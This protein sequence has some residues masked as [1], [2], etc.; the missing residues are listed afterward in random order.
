M[1]LSLRLTI[2]TLRQ[3]P[4]QFLTMGFANLVFR[5]KSTLMVEKSLSTNYRLSYSS[6]SNVQHSKTSPYHLQC[7]AQVKVFNKTVKKYLASYVDE[8]TLNW[9]NFLPAFMLAYNMSYHSTIAMTP[10]EL[11]FGVKPHLPSLP[12]PEIECQHYGE[13]FAAERLQLLQHTHK[14]AHQN[15]QEK[16]LKYKDNFDAKAACLS[17]DNLQGIKGQ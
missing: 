17:K 10:F 9:N 15:A 14:V 8:S 13:S 12:S 7:N 6:C 2:R 11:L 3:L 1:Q 16:G 5:C 4:E